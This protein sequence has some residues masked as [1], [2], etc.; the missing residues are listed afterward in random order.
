MKQ[1]LDENLLS[2]YDYHL[3]NELIAS[4]PTSPRESARLLVYERATK[5]IFHSTFSKL[6]DFIQPDTSIILNDTKVIKARL[7]GK[8]QSGG[9][10]ELLLN[11]PIH[12]NLFKVYIRGRVKENSIIIFENN[13]QAKVIKLMDDGARVVEFTQD[14]KK[15]DMASLYEMLDNI[16]HIPLPPYIKREDE[17]ID[18]KEYQSVFA[19]NQGAVAAPTAS[20]HFSDKMYKDM[21]E[22]FDTRFITLHIGA[23]TFKGVDSEDINQHKMHEEFYNIPDSTRELI[24][25]DKKLLCV[26]TTST[27][28]VEFYKRVGKTSGY[29]NLFLNPNNKPIRANFLLTNFHLPKSTLIMLIASFIGLEETL[30]VYKNAVDEKYRFFSYGDAMLII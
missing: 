12:D 22:K 1:N 4:Y 19:A 28:V 25:S 14:D 26:G 17:S 27:R 30:R 11:S 20:L 8:K 29:C 2:S 24:D 15:I 10:I 13:L 5:K 6:F 21:R 16:G 7:Y 23:G 9:S 3:P 18:V